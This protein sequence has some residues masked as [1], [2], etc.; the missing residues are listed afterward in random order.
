MTGGAPQPRIKA[1]RRTVTVYSDRGTDGG[2]P[3]FDVYEYDDPREAMESQGR[4]LLTV[5]IADAP[6]DSSN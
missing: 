2:L 6:A 4:I 3:L 1:R 5:N